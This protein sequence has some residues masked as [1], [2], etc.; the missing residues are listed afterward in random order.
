M[1]ASLDTAG[2]AQGVQE[3]PK[4]L[5]QPFC[6]QRSK[7]EQRNQA[8]LAKVKQQGPDR[9]CRPELA[10]AYSLSLGSWP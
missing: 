2:E 8:D 6:F 7:Q 3:P 9:N 5:G 10:R 4:P 1:L